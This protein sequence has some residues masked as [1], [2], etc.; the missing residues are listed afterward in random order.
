MLQTPLA[1]A[2]CHN[3]PINQCIGDTF[4]VMQADGKQLVFLKA[5]LHTYVWMHLAESKLSKIIMIP[6]NVRKEKMEDLIRTLE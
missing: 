4:L 6:I 1:N 5:I 2:R 3:F